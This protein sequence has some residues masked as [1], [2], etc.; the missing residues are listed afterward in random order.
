MP[1]DI[2]TMIVEVP[3]VNV[4]PA[5]EVFMERMVS[6][7]LPATSVP[8]AVTVR[9]DAPVMLLL[10]VVRVP[11]TLSVFVTSIAPPWVIVPLTVR[12]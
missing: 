8:V 10:D 7:E 3:T 6:D 1:P 11:A 4:A 2:P 12:L 5:A 9:L